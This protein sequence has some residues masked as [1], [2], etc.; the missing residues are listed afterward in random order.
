M[1]SIQLQ[2]HHQKELDIFELRIIKN[3]RIVS[4]SWR[5]HRQM[6]KDRNWFQISQGTFLYS[7]DL[8]PHF[9]P[10]LNFGSCPIQHMTYLQ[11]RRKYTC[12]AN[13]QNDIYFTQ[14]WPKLSFW[15]KIV[16]ILSVAQ[17]KPKVILFSAWDK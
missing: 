17:L 12:W 11:L 16:V 8:G 6:F 9:P 7:M 14:K 10:V 3:Q 2:F 13:A 15:V 1:V 5:S 4:G